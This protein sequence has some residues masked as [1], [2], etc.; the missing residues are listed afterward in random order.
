MHSG[1]QYFF[2]ILFIFYIFIFLKI[3]A[4]RYFSN[5][6]SEVE[7]FVRTIQTKSEVEKNDF[8]E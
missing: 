6:L 1:S 3:V 2:K 8:F 5:P 7:H 4:V